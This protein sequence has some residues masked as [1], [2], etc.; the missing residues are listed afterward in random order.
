MDDPPGPGA[1]WPRLVFSAGFV[2]LL[3]T[4]ARLVW[5]TVKPPPAVPAVSLSAKDRVLLVRK[6]AAV[7]PELKALDAPALLAEPRDWRSRLF[8]EPVRIESHVYWFP[9]PPELKPRAEAGQRYPLRNHPYTAFSCKA[10]EAPMSSMYEITGL[11]AG[12]LPA[13]LRGQVCLAVGII[14]GEPDPLRQVHGT[15]EILALIPGTKAGTKA[16]AQAVVAPLV[17]ETQRL[18]ESLAPPKGAPP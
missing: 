15:V 18:I 3:I 17:P 4:S 9:E 8:V 5:R 10:A 1:L 2:L 13:L 14:P 7:H 6:L 12:P 16:I 11:L